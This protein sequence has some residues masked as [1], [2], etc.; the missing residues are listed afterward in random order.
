MTGPSGPAGVTGA[1][2]TGATGPTG[3]AGTAGAAGATGPTGPTGPTGA[4]GP[5]GPTGPTGATGATGVTGTIGLVRTANKISAY[6]AAPND[7]VACD[8]SGGS[9]TV[10]LPTAPANGTTIGVKI[11]VGN[12]TGSNGFILT[13]AAGG[14][15]VFDNAGGATTQTMKILSQEITYI[16]QTSTGIWSAA[17]GVLPLSRLN[18]TRPIAVSTTYTAASGDIVLATA[19]AGG[20]TVTLPT[21]ALGAFVTVKKV[22]T[23]AGT[24]TVSPAS[25][26]IDGASTYSLV[27][28]WDSVDLYSDGSNWFLNNPFVANANNESVIRANALNQFAGATG[29]VTLAGIQ[30]TALSAPVI[31][32][33]SGTWTPST[34]G[35]QIFAAF[36]V[37]GGGNGRAGTT[38]SP[39]GGGGGGQ[40]LPFAYLGN[41]TGAQTVTIGAGG[42]SGAGGATTIGSLATAAGGGQPPAIS[43]GQDIGGLG[44]DGGFGGY[45]ANTLIN[46]GGTGGGGGGGSAGTAG[47]VGG[48]GTG[49]FGAGGGAGGGTVTSGGPG[50]GAGANRGAG[51][52]GSTNSG[53]GG[54]GAGSPL[55]AGTA[56][57]N[58]SSTTGAA[59]GAAAANSGGGGGGG[60]QGS[61][62]GGAGAAGGSGYVIIYQLA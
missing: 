59:G 42:T 45:N 33:S 52:T 21:V 13:V 29:V 34:L 6:T 60:G 16:Y 23:G 48:P 43:G 8:I 11:V 12:A 32:T 30:G 62:A 46:P 35:Q 15:D 50:G 3:P 40:V 51:G 36:M 27:V 47:G 56:G 57:S 1:G 25:G 39:G 4:T 49:G 5:T 53:G 18:A 10:T 22:D 9:F 44:G 58:G 17:I 26:S 7:L 20:F 28:R 54:G 41:V 24:I 19:G 55:G 2:V 14:T 38:A 61:V 37:G 31:F